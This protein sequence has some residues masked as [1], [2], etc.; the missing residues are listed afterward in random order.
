[1][2]IPK[3]VEKINFHCN[4]FLLPSEVLCA[5]PEKAVNLSDDQFYCYTSQLKYVLRLERYVS[6][7]VGQNS[8][9]PCG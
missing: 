3:Y 2:F 8:L 9:T 5:C 4:K 1:M 7:V 6:R